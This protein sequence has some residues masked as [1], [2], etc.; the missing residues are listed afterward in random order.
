MTTERWEIED[1]FAR[2]A[3]VL[4]EGTPDDI[5]QVY[6]KDILVRSPRGGELRG[7]DEVLDYLRSTAVDGE[8]TQ[9]VHSDILV[10]VDGD[11][12]ETSANQLTFFYRDGEAPHRRAGLRLKYTAVRTDQGWRFEEA[13]IGRAWVQEN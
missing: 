10:S 8:L 6:T 7:I 1:L 13:N 5:R 2:L 12:A 11:R 4:D 3:R 9:H